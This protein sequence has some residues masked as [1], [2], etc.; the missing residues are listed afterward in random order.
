MQDRGF[1]IYTPVQQL[2]RLLVFSLCSRV[3]INIRVCF[4]II[5]WSFYKMSAV[6]E[7]KTYCVA[8]T[9]ICIRGEC[10]LKSKNL[11]F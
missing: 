1:S 11:N 4:E 3:N 5:F 6:N 8:D 10:H 2:L 9:Q 7:C